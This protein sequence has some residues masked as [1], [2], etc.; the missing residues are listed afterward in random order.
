MLYP[1]QGFK[2]PILFPHHSHNDQNMAR[3]MSPLFYVGPIYHLAFTK[4]DKM[5]MLDATDLDVVSDLKV[6]LCHFRG[7]GPS[8][9]IL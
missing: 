3:Y 1:N 7:L 5:I 2:D 9:V 4:L 6:L 8:C